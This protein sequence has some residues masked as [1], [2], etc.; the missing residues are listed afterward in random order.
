MQSRDTSLS[1]I[2][3]ERRESVKAMIGLFVLLSPLI[4]LTV[5]LWW[6][7]A[8]YQ[9][10]SDTRRAILCE[11]AHNYL[12]S[13]D[14]A[15]VARGGVIVSEEGCRLALNGAGEVDARRM[16][17]DAYLAEHPDGLER[18]MTMTAAGRPGSGI[19]W[20]GD[21]FLAMMATFLL[22]GIGTPLAF[23]MWHAP[24]N[25]DGTPS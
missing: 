12:A 18:L 24:A 5:W 1:P 16:L 8:H 3:S 20:H 21:M 6:S 10:L 23:V 17:L 25:E 14:P 22:I 2:A 7:T 13:S 4:V 9:A 11:R 15:D 19:P